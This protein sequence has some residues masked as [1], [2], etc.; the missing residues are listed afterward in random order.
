MIIQLKDINTASQRTG[1]FL[2]FIQLKNIN[3]ASQLTGGFL[4]IMELKY[5]IR[6]HWWVS[7]DSHNKNRLFSYVTIA[8]ALYN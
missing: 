3:T 8:G 5:F 7:Y 4:M 1:R 2:V 6:A